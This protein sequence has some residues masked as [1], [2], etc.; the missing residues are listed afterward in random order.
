MN[1]NFEP[2]HVTASIPPDLH[3]RLSYKSRLLVVIGKYVYGDPIAWG[4]DCTAE[5]FYCLPHERPLVNNKTLHF[6]NAGND[7]SLK[8]NLKVNYFRLKA[9]QEI[10]Y[11]ATALAVVLFLGTTGVSLAIDKSK[12][13]FTS[14][15]SYVSQTYQKMNM[16]QD[17]KDIARLAEITAIANDLQSKLGDGKIS[18]DELNSEMKQLTEEYKTLKEK[19]D[20]KDPAKIEEKKQ[21]QL[22][23][24]KRLQ[25]EKLKAEQEAKAKADALEQERLQAEAQAQIQAQAPVQVE[26][27]PVEVKKVEVKPA[28]KVEVKPQMSE[29]QKKELQRK[30]MEQFTSGEISREEMLAKIRKIN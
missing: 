17:E 1:N 15:K 21:A 9:K 23:E 16:T 7:Y 13:V 22:A 24:E 29:V 5:E 30:Y 10:M 4:L 3:K 6:K 27:K 25:D 18:Q 19:V 2:I 12:A 26:Q 14:T 11:G 20:S 8:R 28:P